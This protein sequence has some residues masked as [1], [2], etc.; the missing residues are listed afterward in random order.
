MHPTTLKKHPPIFFT[1]C[2]NLFEIAKRIV[3]ML[4]KQ[5]PY[6]TVLNI[7]ALQNRSLREAQ[8]SI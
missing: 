4:P 6:A 1:K 3:H 8:E 5:I 7:V 2:R